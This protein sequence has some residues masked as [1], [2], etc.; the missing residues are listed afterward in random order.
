MEGSSSKLLTRLT[1][2]SPSRRTNSGARR[3]GSRARYVLSHIA[4]DH[5]AVTQRT[6]TSTRTY[7]HKH[8]HMRTHTFLCARIQH[9][10]P[11]YPS[12]IH[13]HVHTHVRTH[14]RALPRTCNA[15]LQNWPWLE[16]GELS[17][18]TPSDCMP[19]DTARQP[20][21][22]QQSCMFQVTELTGVTPRS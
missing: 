15:L 20:Q 11:L 21:Q 19:T 5:V 6:R 22:G 13:T 1:L 2:L 4:T 16:R 17:Y 8:T 12:N 18:M 14:A 7:T 3:A 9:F 10:L